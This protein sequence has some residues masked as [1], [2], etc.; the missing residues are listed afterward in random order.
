MYHAFDVYA[1]DVVVQY[2]MGESFHYLDDPEF[3]P[4]YSKT[5]EAI[6]Q[7]GVQFKLFQWIMGLFEPLPRWVVVLI[8]PD[9]GSVI[10][11]KVNILRLANFVRES[12]TPRRDPS[13]EKSNL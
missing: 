13:N 3:T 6:V 7:V 8:N 5:I 10:D 4:Q 2:S 11:Q 9:I 12:Q 1:T